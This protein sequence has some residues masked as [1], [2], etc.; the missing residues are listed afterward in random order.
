MTEIVTNVSKEQWTSFLHRCSSA[1]IY[2][3]PEWKSFLEKTFGYEPHYL[4]AKDEN[5]NIVGLLPLFDVKSKLTGNR[6]CSV[7]FSHTCG[8]IGDNQSLSM[9]VDEA[10]SIFDDSEAKFIEIRNPIKLNNFE[11]INSYS[12]Y[13]LDVSKNIDEI[14]KNL[15]SNARRATRKSKKIGLHV[16]ATNDISDLKIFYDINCMTKKKIGVP[17]H[18]WKHFKNMFDIFKGN[19]LL[20]VVEYNDEIIAGGIREY[21]HETIIAGYAAADPNYVNLNPYNALNWKTIEDASNSGYKY[22]DLG[23]VSYDNKG[24]MFFKSRWG[25]TEKKLYYSFYPKNPMSLAENR[26]N[27]KYRIGTKIIRKMPLPL[28]EKFSDR[29][30]GSFG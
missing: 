29:I 21:Y 17:C 28:Y 20:Y 2:H 13:I 7:P 23:R 3:T 19:I 10:I 4:F 11:N 15:S 26:D 14:W 9:L 5:E 25:T 22:Y 16:R 12:T 8:P 30:F 18:P 6:L 24:L 1:T 27:F